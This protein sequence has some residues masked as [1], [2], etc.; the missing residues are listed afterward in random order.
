MK[1]NF[2]NLI[3]IMGIGIILLLLLKYFYFNN[4]KNNFLRKK[5]KANLELKN[6]IHMSDHI[7]FVGQDDEYV[8]LQLL[9]D[10]FHFIKVDNNLKKIDTINLKMSKDFQTESNIYSGRLGDDIYL[11]NP[12]SD[13][14]KFKGNNIESYKVKK[15]RFSSIKPVSENSIIGRAKSSENRDNHRELVKIDL[16]DDGANRKKY[17]IPKQVDGFF[18]SDGWLHYDKNNEKILYMYFYRGQVL[19][20]D[21]NLNLEYKLKTIDTVTRAAIKVGLYNDKLQDG[22]RVS[23]LTQITPSELTNRYLTTYENKIYVLS[24]L[25]AD[26]DLTSE[27]NENQPVDVYSLNNGKYL[28]SFYIPKYKGQ[29][30]NFFQIK[31][32][33]IIAIFGTNLVTF[34][35][36]GH[37]I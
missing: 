10:K 37:I 36:K 15:L 20:L 9:K 29:G 21:T 19:C 11:S 24:G 18:C 26:N 16:K 3:L 28:Y 23:R 7:F 33:K 8:V 2:F 1:K 12:Y 13:V 4:N 34:E 5:V 31:K 35:F 30:I 32:N 17:I 27:F 22:S 14:I 6:V 25:K